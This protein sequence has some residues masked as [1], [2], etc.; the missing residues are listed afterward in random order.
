MAPGLS[1]PHLVPSHMGLQL[2]IPPLPGAYVTGLVSAIS[3][4]VL[5]HET[6]TACGQSFLGIIL[7]L[8]I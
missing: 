3:S 1:G 7:T 5:T 6:S 2:H 4:Q 8:G